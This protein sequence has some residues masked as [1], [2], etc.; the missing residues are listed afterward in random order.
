MWPCYHSVQT[1]SLCMF[2]RSRRVLV[3][4]VWRENKIVFFF[5]Y[6]SKKIRERS[7]VDGDFVVEHLYMVRDQSRKHVYIFLYVNA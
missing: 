7:F 1:L 2:E 5:L 4:F 6:I 3:I